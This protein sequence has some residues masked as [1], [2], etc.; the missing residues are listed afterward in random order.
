MTETPKVRRAGHGGD[1]IYWDAAKNRYVG[2]V[3]L[4]YVPNGERRRPKVYGKTKTARSAR[5]SGS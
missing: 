5:R 2:A 1:T 3:S 4:G